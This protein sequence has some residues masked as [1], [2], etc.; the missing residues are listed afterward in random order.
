MQY[1]EPGLWGA[2]STTTAPTATTL[3]HFAVPM[4]FL[5]RDKS[6]PHL[7]HHSAGQRQSVAGVPSGFEEPS[8]RSENH[9]PTA[10]NGTSIGPNL[11]PTGGVMGD[12]EEKG[13]PSK[14]SSDTVADVQFR[15][16]DSGRDRDSR[17]DSGL[18]AAREQPRDHTTGPRQNR[19]SIPEN[20]SRVPSMSH[21]APA[22]NEADKDT[23]NPALSF[24]FKNSSSRRN[25]A[26]SQTSVPS[27]FFGFT[28][29]LPGLSNSHHSSIPAVPISPNTQEFE[30]SHSKKFVPVQHQSEN[31]SPRLSFANLALL[32]NHSQNSQP[33]PH[34]GYR[35]FHKK[36]SFSNVP[37]LQH[38]IRPRFK[39]KGTSLLGKL[40]HS[41]RKGSDPSIYLNDDLG[42][43]TGAPAA[44]AAS[45]NSTTGSFNPSAG[46][47]N[48]GLSPQN[49]KSV[50]SN[51]SGKHK[52]RLSSIT[53]HHLHH[54]GDLHRTVSLSEDSDKMSDRLSAPNSKHNSVSGPP[55][56]LHE[57]HSKSISGS[58]PSLKR[59]ASENSSKFFDL[60]LNFDELLSIL[61][62]P[63]AAQNTKEIPNE[64][65]K[66]ESP[67]VSKHHEKHSAWKA[68]DSWDVPDTQAPQDN[69]SLLSDLSE[70]DVDKKPPKPLVMN[71]SGVSSQNSVASEDL[72]HFQV[73]S[74]PAADRKLK[75][76][77]DHL[78][79]LPQRA[80][81]ILYGHILSSMD[82]SSTGKQTGPS[83][84]IRIFKEDNTFTTAACPLGTTTAEL[85]SIIKKKFFL[86]SI[87]NYQL[88]LYVGNNVKVLEPFEKPIQIHTGLLSL[89]GYTSKDN[90]RMIGRED[91]LSICKF[92][93]ENTTL[94]NITFEEEASLS[95]DYVNV[96]ISS[97]NLK[98]I[99]IIFHQHTYEIERLN[100]SDNP[101]IY[102]PL[103]FIQ[104]ST[105]LWSIKSSR[106]G[107]S[108]FPVNFL[109]ASELKH[110]LVDQNFLDEIPARL[111]HLKKLEYL[112]LNSNQIYF[113]PKSFE[114][115]KTLTTL[116]LSS[117]YFQ[118]YPECINE[119]TNLQDLDFSYNDLA[120]IPDSI[121]NLHKLTKLNF[122]T[123][124][125]S[126]A[127]PKGMSKLA[128]LKRLDI[129]YNQI[130]NID[131]LGS[132]PNLEVFYAS[133]NAISSFS[134][135][136]EK[137]RLLHFD[138]NP[139]TSL[140]FEVML[141]MLTVLDL[142]KAKITAL[143]AEFIGKIP[144][145][146]KLVLD[147]NHLVTLPE[148]MGNLP[149]L[150]HLSLFSNNIQNIPASIGQ[151]FSLQYLN[152]H[153]NNIGVLPSEI[154]N[155]KSLT[156]LNISSNILSQFPKPTFAL[157]KKM[158]STADFSLEP[159]DA[160]LSERT[161]PTCLRDNLLSLSA[162]DNSLTDESFESIALLSNLRT[163]NLSYNDLTEIPE[164][165][166]A[167]LTRLSELFISGN[168]LTRLPSEDLESL[169]DLRWLYLNNNKFPTLPPELSKCQ[170]L[171]HLDVGSNLLRY[172]IANWPYDWNWAYNK[173]LR[174]LNFSGN[175]RFEIKQSYAQNSETKETY[176]NLL[177]LKELRAIGLMDVTLTSPNVPDLTVDVRSRTTSSELENVGY[178]IADFMANH[179]TI[180]FR[181]AFI[182]K[183][184]G[185]DNEMLILSCDGIGATNASLGGHLISYLAKQL[186]VPLFTA[187]LDKISSDED[188]PDALRRSFLGLNN[189]INSVL[190]NKKLGFFT[191]STEFP[192]LNDLKL[193]E[194]AVKGSCMCV[195]Y[196]KAGIIYA[197]NVGDI[198]TVVSRNNA[199]YKIL[200]TKHDPT[201]RK[202]FERIRASGGYVSGGG[203]LD[204]VLHVSRGVGFFN[205]VP[206]THS[207]PS[208]SI[209]DTAG[210][211][212]VLIMASRVLWDYLSYDLAVDI[213]RQEQDDPMVAAEKLRDH[214][215]FYGASDKMSV[216]VVSVGYEKK[217]QK[218]LSS[219]MNLGRDS[220]GFQ[221]RKRRERGAQV[222]DSA[223]RRLNDE[224]DPPVGELALVFTDIKN[225]T[226]LWDAYPVAM[227]SA[228][229]L[230]NTIMRRQLRIV[231][232]YEVKTEGDS[233]MVSFPTPTSALLWCFN[234]QNQL[235][236]EDWPT[237]ILET[238]ECCEVTDNAGKLVF[239]GLSVRMGI[240]WGSPVCE[241]DMVTRRM[242][243]F[244]P[245]VNRASRIESSADGGQIA[246]STDF[247][248][249]MEQLYFLHEQ[250]ESGAI[251]AQ[252]GFEGTAGAREI[253]GSEI[254]ALEEIGCQ[255][256][257]LGERKLKGLE[258]PENIVLAFP[259]NLAIRY[260]I[261][262][263]RLLRDDEYLGRIVGA[264][265][266]ELIFQL[267]KV[268]LRLENTCSLLNAGFTANEDTFLRPNGELY[269]AMVKKNV[270]EYDLVALFNHLTTRIEN[271]VAAFELRQAY[272]EMHGQPA[273]EFTQDLPIWKMVDDLKELMRLAGG[274]QTTG[275]QKG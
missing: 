114:R 234:V 2:P 221:G 184:R 207:G 205:Y 168:S 36:G 270:Q 39:K 156:Y 192:E 143:P 155:L 3:Y 18:G 196:I 149:R 166:L 43:E 197:A 126:K 142:S 176:D 62:E 269:E 125:L 46:S 51:S 190:A 161:G 203:A 236:S 160:T 148:E 15:S 78:L 248:H 215:I 26:H 21:I 158:S 123:N 266:V 262:M 54:F 120:I 60:N 154:W 66:V 122:S 220:G 183:F 210:G 132:L 225:S 31:Y 84:I 91:I 211:D 107:A 222:G 195:L 204:G 217:S 243:Y 77:L 8:H 80:L 6:R 202:E 170:L 174:Y 169:T 275:N 164:G 35:G 253:I 102:I 245:M 261:F 145:I 180:A 64:Q 68:P 81:P 97:R 228:I 23:E 94:R 259:S 93:V 230:H 138:R 115:L 109:E 240:H 163:L 40:I 10:A 239:R 52:F 106:N 272:H 49:R 67:L 53:S 4:S 251:N 189:Q 162:A 194:D 147:K 153:S 178:G 95:K 38:P 65:D 252:A 44:T 182:Q 88:T 29:E 141:H 72:S 139:V 264:L 268:S 249:E 27:F 200:T 92:V 165:A 140:E 37:P 89:S 223:L 99:P 48:P 110:L 100:V 212:V 19:K 135:K 13:E 193:S 105:N 41:N 58:V 96:D 233:F 63:P 171:T 150:T 133:K 129:R 254:R 229:K 17:R 75:R 271:C 74:A 9:D 22:K 116:N 267:R 241:P 198:E 159:Q 108:K 226:L 69:L 57:T 59:L 131:V 255:Y 11:G 71:P 263:K 128:H 20:P 12:L 61:K 214:A 119:L 167:R 152:L 42:S 50:S 47:A 274:R 219:Y 172:N 231:G 175:K 144:H 118:V 83:Y 238:N 104:S 45:G 112:Q 85:L 191:P 242:D 260:E 79:L 98:T 208:I 258:I 76:K 186:L 32:S 14:P 103:D 7:L 82:D 257:E 177:V 33:A 247:L 181:D 213:A 199:D 87:S 246:V 30:E 117:N 34:D 235:L 24:Q 1:R 127:L 70:S 232:G 188:I 16:R 130:S 206:H 136:M 124:K 86:D 146:E 209:Y 134:D 101:A 157:V 28:K 237:Q 250:I 173:R 187:E 224:I 55:G 227:R 73:E 121:G 179:E 151:L 201:L 218:A 25:T 265:P 113:L 5:R 244:G 137:L 90:M 185:N 56:P 256:F 273:I 216:T 111:S